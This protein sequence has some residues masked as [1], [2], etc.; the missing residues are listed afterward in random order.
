MKI[1][2]KHLQR[3]IKEEVR[4]VVEEI[5]TEDEELK[6]Y[7]RRQPT[8][9]FEEEEEESGDYEDTLRQIQKCE[10]RVEFLTQRLDRCLN[11]KKE[12]QDWSSLWEE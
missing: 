6:R 5:D 10:D 8:A 4:K 11:K 9:E 2:Q 7:A 3:I 1:S 12:R